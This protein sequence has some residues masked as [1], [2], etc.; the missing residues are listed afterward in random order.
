MVLVCR[1]VSVLPCALWSAAAISFTTEG[2]ESLA[3]FVLFCLFLL[4]IQTIPG[5]PNVVDD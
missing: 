5:C 3:G 2:M 4:N 1:G